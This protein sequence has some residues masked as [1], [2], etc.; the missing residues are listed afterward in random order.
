MID[1]KNC[2][3]LATKKNYD[4]LIEDGFK[5]DFKLD[6]NRVV[7]YIGLR[8]CETIWMCSKSATMKQFKRQI[9][10]VDDKWK[11]VN[12]LERWGF[13]VKEG[14]DIYFQDNNKISHGL[15]NGFSYIWK[16]NGE[17]Y[18]LD[19]GFERVCKH[20]L[21]PIVKVSTSDSIKEEL[22][23]VFDGIRESLDENR[24]FLI[25]ITINNNF[26]KKEM[27]IVINYKN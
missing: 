11:E 19:D 16:G 2:Y 23:L 26:Q 1:L 3:C 18:E 6:G 15:V 22:L 14:V 25:D 4:R 8:E 9:Q 12:I 5:L 17:C 13:E 7:N 27:N 10:L 20:D 21:I 24:I